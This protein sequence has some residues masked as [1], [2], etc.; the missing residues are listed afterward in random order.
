MAVYPGYPS[1]TNTYVPSTA[2]SGSLVV[3]FSRNPNKF[4][5]SSYTKYIPCQNN[6]GL[7][8]VWTSQEAARVYTDTDNEHNWA[9]GDAAPAGADQ[10]ESFARLPFLTVRKAYPY[11]FGAMAVDQADFA[12]LALQGAVAAQKAMTARTVWTQY[13]LRNAAWGANTAHVDG[14]FGSPAILASGQN[15]TTGGVGY[16]ATSN[17]TGA[18]GPNIKISLNYG[19]IAINQATIGVVGMRQTALVIN[20]NCA[21]QMSQSTEIQ[22]YIKQSPVALAQLRGDSPSQNGEWGLPDTLYGHRVIVEDTVRIA[23]N[24]NITGTSTNT[25]TM[26]D[27]D[28]FLLAVDGD[29]EGL[30]G[31]PNFTTVQLFFYKDEMTVETK[32]DSDNRRYMGRVVSNYVP[33]VVSPSSGFYFQNVLG[34]TT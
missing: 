10:L 17:Y 1:G 12:L 5:I 4:P 25:Y 3:G 2:A 14:A 22:D 26:K 31:S 8:T 15:W 13:V 21:T 23:T 34:G 28:A 33:I 32:Y 29:I 18:E 16:G 24:P 30:E 6:Q 7:Y 11:L 20:P 19:S 27:N 9:D